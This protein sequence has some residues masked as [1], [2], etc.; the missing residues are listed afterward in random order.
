LSHCLAENDAKSIQRRLIITSAALDQVHFLSARIQ[1]YISS[2]ERPR[3]MNI[4]NDDDGRMVKHGNLLLPDS[5]VQ[6]FRHNLT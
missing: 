5:G 2:T 1:E 3:S 4:V 6:A